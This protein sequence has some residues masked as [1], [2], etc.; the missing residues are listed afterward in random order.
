VSPSYFEAL[1]IT[2]VRGRAFSAYDRSS[3][4]P[5]A[6]I[7]RAMADR[8]WP[9]GDPFGDRVI[10]F[11]GPKPDDEPRRAIVG[12]V[13]NARDG[14][15]LE[16]TWQPTVY[17]PLAQLL[18]RET[19]ILLRDTPLIWIVRPSLEPRAI[20]ASAARAL[21]ESTGP[22]TAVGVQPLSDVL[23]R[24]AAPTNFNMVVLVLFGSAALLLAVTGVYGVTAYAVQQRGREIAVRWALGATPARLQRMVLWQG[25][26]LVG[27]S[28]A[29][30]FVAAVALGRLLRGAFFSVT[31]DEPLVFALGPLVLA[32]AAAAAMWLPTRRATA[33]PM[34]GIRD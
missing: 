23:A 32:C 12:V 16:R 29:I 10:T 1:G 5:V 15:P 4:P 9:G 31:T 17:I 30:G 19:A 14:D 25:L 11:P 8:F 6:I 18:D 34:V 27:A 22:R 7:N 21:R 28:L 13:E 20:A 33:D 26:R 24:S 3:A 2:V